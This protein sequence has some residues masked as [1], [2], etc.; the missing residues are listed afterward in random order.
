MHVRRFVLLTLVAQ[1]LLGI[2]GVGA[3][4]AAVVRGYDT[5]RGEM[6]SVMLISDPAEDE[7]N[8]TAQNAQT[9]SVIGL[10]NPITA[11][12]DKAGDVDW[13]KFNTTAEQTYVVELFNVARALGAG[14]GRCRAGGSGVGIKIFD[15][16]VT[17]IMEQCNADGAGNVHNLVAFKAGIEGTFYIQVLPNSGTS[18]GSYSLRVLPRHDEPGA[19]WDPATTEPN[20]IAANAYAIGLND[21]NTITGTIEERNSSY[22]TTAVDQDWYRFSANAGQTYVVE[23]FDVAR[24][25]GVGL[26]RCR[27]GGIGVGIKIYDATVTQVAEQCAANGAGNVHN[28]VQFKAGMNGTIYIQVLPNNNVDVA[29]VY[30]IRVLPKHDDP[31]ASWNSSTFEPNNWTINAYPIGLGRI[32]ELTSTIEERNSSYATNNVDRDAYRFEA[33]ANQEYTVELLNVDQSLKVSGV[34]FCSVSYGI[35]LAIYDPTLTEITRRCAAQDANEIHSSLT[36]TT[37]VN[38]PYYIWVIP[39]GVNASGNYSIR[40]LSEADRALKIFLP[41]ITH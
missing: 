32:N 36:L 11:Q 24:A 34:S 37:G 40:V 9:L 38:G 13:Y 12:I 8:D 35:A 1:I 14:L 2:W 17:Q 16:T 15:A 20:N 10:N 21:S 28:H 19:A 30:K 27:A 23:L 25:L 6:K 5:S 18:T 22:S 7:P 29:G 26:G 41:L 31:A 3:T 33:T 4:N 39:N